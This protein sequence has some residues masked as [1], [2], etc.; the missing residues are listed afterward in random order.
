MPNHIKNRLVLQGSTEDVADLI[1][2]FSTS[3]ERTPRKAHDNRL[4]YEKKDSGDFGWFDPSDNSFEF[5]SRDKRGTKTIGIPEGYVQDFDEAWVRFPDFNKIKPMPK[6]LEI[7]SGSLGETAH[8][9]LFGTKKKK[10][11]PSTH[12][13]NQASFSKLSI[14]QQ[15]KAVE[16][17]IQYEDNLKKYGHATWYDWAVEHWGTK[18][19]SYSCETIG[20]H[21]QIYEFQTAWSGIPQLIEAMS[22]ECPN[23]YITYKYADEDTGCNVGIGKY[24]NGE[25]SF[26]ILENNSKE[27]YEQCFI[28]WPDKK[29]N[30]KLVNNTYEYIEDES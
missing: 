29:D 1:A 18:W 30:Y 11:F 7:E 5:G 22:K 3:F 20:D 8:E 25:T 6:S 28:L 10:F 23:V 15:K 26:N 9:L 27:A 2:K 19:N 4:I 16:L 14:E 17:A 24:K 13:S 21:A 12:E